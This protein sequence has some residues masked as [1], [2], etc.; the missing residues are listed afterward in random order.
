MIDGTVEDAVIK[1]SRAGVTIFDTIRFQLDDGSS[2]TVKKLVA[3]Q[4]VAEF[5]TPGA[6]GR[7]YLSNVFDLKALHG[8]RL[9]GGRAACDF[10]GNNAKIFLLSAAMALLLI[11]LRVLTEGDVP[12]LGLGLLILGVVG[13]A[14][15]RKGQREALQQFES[16]TSYAA[17]T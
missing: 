3:K 12:L 5:I 16:D 4:A 13:W 6:R 9:R 10:P 11:A 17:R 8:V 15:T 2:R 14:L 7:F 1:R